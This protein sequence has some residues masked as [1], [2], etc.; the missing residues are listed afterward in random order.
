VESVRQHGGD[1]T[2]VILHGINFDEAQVEAKR[3]EK[4]EGY[5]L[6]PPFDDPLVIAGQ[7]TCGMEILKQSMGKDIDA[8]FVCC[9]GGGFLA[10]IAAVVKRI[11][12]EIK[13][14]GVE[15]AD[16]A[17][18]TNSLLAGRVVALPTVGLFA[19]GAAV[20]IVGR[21]TF[22]L[23]SKYVDDMITV[24][25]DEICAAIKD[26]FNDTRII[27][28]P[29]GALAI[30]GMKRYITQ[31]GITRKTFV[32]TASGA[33]MD[34]DRVR[35]VADRADIRETLISVTIPEK[36]GSFRELY[37][38]IFPRNVTEFSYRYRDPNSANIIL[39]FHAKSPEDSAK[40]ISKLTDKGYEV[41]ELSNNE[42]AKV[43]ARHLAGGRAPNVKNEVLYRF[44]FPE[45]PGALNDF[46]QKI[47]SAWN[48]SLFHYR[49]HGADVGRV[50][51]GMQ[52]PDQ[53]RTKF[54]HFLR[55]LGYVYIDESSNPVYRSF[56]L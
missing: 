38:Q 46:L 45:R 55:E 12:P 10:G 15:A 24:S 22:R 54:D 23:C 52:I 21:E 39:S 29:A 18:M 33:N 48:V 17:G 42:M 26:G 51:V 40:V 14:I 53:D 49:N 5:T 37:N 7:G 44:E 43:H 6:I 2:E 13:I 9:G 32:A 47:S 30:A 34:F 16:A 28:E 27:L 50:L 1:Y 11:R 8:I 36:A 41:M 20:K 4:E 25:T 19:D 31:N 3:L 35:F 56:L